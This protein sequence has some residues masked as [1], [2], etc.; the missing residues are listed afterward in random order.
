MKR[1]HPLKTT[2]VK[3]SKH[4]KCIDNSGGGKKHPLIWIRASSMIALHAG[5]AGASKSLIKN[6]LITVDLAKANG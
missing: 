5:G 6:M 3:V 2:T 4:H 1:E